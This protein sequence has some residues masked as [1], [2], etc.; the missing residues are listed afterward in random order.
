MAK[1]LRCRLRLHAWED[2]ENPETGSGIRSAFAAMRTV[3]EV[4]RRHRELG[5]PDL[6]GC[7]ACRCRF[8]DGLPTRWGLRFDVLEH[9]EMVPS[10]SEAEPRWF[11]IWRA[12]GTAAIDLVGNGPL[13]RG[14]GSGRYWI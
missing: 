14:N 5:V 9:I 3:I 4:F 2:R 7:P 1:P 12:F 13:S 11:G 6:V 10:R 8:A